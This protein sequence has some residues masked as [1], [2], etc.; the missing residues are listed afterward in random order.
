MRQRVAVAFLGLLPVAPVLA[1]SYGLGSFRAWFL[2]TTVPAL[3]ALAVISWRATGLRALVATGAA[4]GVLGTIGY[5]VFRVPF[6]VSGV[7]LFA[8][9]ESYGVLLT[10]AHSSRPVTAF[11]GWCYHLSNGVGFG[12][13][14][15]L[16]MRGRS[17]WWGVLWGL[18]LETATVVT[19]F[20]TMYGL[21]GKWDLI[22]IAYAA[23][24]FYG[25]P[26][27]YVVEKASPL[28]ALKMIGVGVVA[29]AV[30]L[31]PWSVPGSTREGERVAPGPSAVVRE[32]RFHPGWLRVPKGGCA[33]IRNDDDRAYDLPKQHATLAPG[34]TTTVCFGTVGVLRV[35]TS[36]EPYSGGF[37]I[38]ERPRG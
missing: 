2:A 11:A 10:G 15:G 28:P 8:P 19:P 33:A 30:W 37:V 38:V 20:A 26:L 27:G 31:R 12:I 5:D 1:W 17:R 4:G 32:G 36:T 16:L 22:G 14:Y 23:H 29:I 7:R 24:V 34:T 13:A 9:I 18:V 35:R 6:A 21:R 25:L 3:V